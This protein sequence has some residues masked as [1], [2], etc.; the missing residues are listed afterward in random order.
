MSKKDEMIPV[1]RLDS[2]I[3]QIRGQK[4]MLDSDLA[5]IYGVSTSRLKVMRR[6]SSWLMWIRRARHVCR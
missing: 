1:E 3:Y 5:R 6:S 2:F 4:V